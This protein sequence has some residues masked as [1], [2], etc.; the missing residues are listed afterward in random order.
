MPQLSREGH[1]PVAAR[2]PACGLQVDSSVATWLPASGASCGGA[3]RCYVASWG[4]LLPGGFPK[5]QPVASDPSR[6]APA[7]TQSAGE[8][9]QIWS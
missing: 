7:H 6:L 8:D 4:G 1:R 2:I 3:V 5:I 9:P